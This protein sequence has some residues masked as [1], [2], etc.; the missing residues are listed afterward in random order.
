MSQGNALSFDAVFP[1]CSAVVSN[2]SRRRPI[3][4][5]RQPAFAN[6]IATARPAPLPAPVTTA[7]FSITLNSGLRSLDFDFGLWTLAFGLIWNCPPPLLLRRQLCR[8]HPRLR[9]RSVGKRRHA[10]PL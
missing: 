1:A 3:S 4:A 5:T 8:V 9:F 10:R 7:V 6:A 2:A